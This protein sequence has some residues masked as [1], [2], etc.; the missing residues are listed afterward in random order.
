MIVRPRP[1][2]LMILLVWRG[3]VLSNILPQLLS[4]GLFASLVVFG[5]GRLFG[6]SDDFTAVP[7]TLFGIAL[8]I[9]LGFRNNASYDRYWEAR[10][11]WGVLTIVSRSLTR[12]AL[13]LTSADPAARSQ[14]V[15][16][17]IGYAHS[18]RHHLRGS[19]ALPELAPLLGADALAQLGRAR[20]RPA[21][22][23]LLLGRTLA[24]WR[25]AGQLEPILA[26][27]LE[28]QLDQLSDVLG[29][30]E[31]IA[32]TPIP[33]AYSV[34]LHRTV[35]IYCLLLPF[36]LVAQ[37]GALTPFIVVFIAYTFLALEALG[38]EIEEPFG[39]AP[40]DLPLNAIC[41]QIEIGLREMLGETDLP[42]PLLPQRYV[43]D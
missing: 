22:I 4:L 16:L 10:K 40:N 5:H 12:Q 38:E 32:T 18:L 24:D 23:L 14:L 26:P 35:F 41:R 42:E 39:T 11:L 9:F 29:G 6:W 37:T 30:C 3:S 28:R 13:T 1:H 21:A 36:G 7:F 27:A 2:W 33:F 17:L 15:R 43:L 31:R 20:N 8:A 25:R 19:D 34:I